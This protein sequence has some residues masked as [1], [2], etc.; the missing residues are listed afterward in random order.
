MVFTAPG[1]LLKAKPSIKQIRVLILLFICIDKTRSVISLTSDKFF[2]IY[3]SIKRNYDSIN[4]ET[5]KVN[6]ES[7]NQK[8]LY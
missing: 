2:L 7:T 4:L 8:N 5:M 1:Y 3:I 6:Y